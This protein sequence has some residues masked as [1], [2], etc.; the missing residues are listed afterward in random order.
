M[1]AVKAVLLLRRVVQVTEVDGEALGLV[2]LGV[3]REHVCV[4]RRLGVGDESARARLESARVAADD[5]AQEARER[6]R[7]E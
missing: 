5:E 3:G 4:L 6:D 1:R 7:H 2:L